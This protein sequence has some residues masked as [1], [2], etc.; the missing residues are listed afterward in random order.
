[1]VQIM[2]RRLCGG[3]PSI[4]HKVRDH[5]FFDFQF[6][7]LLKECAAP[8]E[9]A[10]SVRE[11]ARRCGSKWKQAEL[12]WLSLP[13]GGLIGVEDLISEDAHTIKSTEAASKILTDI[14]E[15]AKGHSKNWRH[16][17]ALDSL[18]QRNEARTNSMFRRLP[19]CEGMLDRSPICLLIWIACSSLA[20]N[21]YKV[22]SLMNTALGSPD[23]SKML[24]FAQRNKIKKTI[25]LE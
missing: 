11:K 2:L 15:F 13:T 12:T 22:L 19:A 24:H 16:F 9:E 6:L 1:M 8:L 17:C 20:P 23:L 25:F 4:Y 5:Y 18:P 7:R 10:L 14:I 21:Q 3:R